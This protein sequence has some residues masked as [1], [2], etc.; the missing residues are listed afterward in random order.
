MSFSKLVE[1]GANLA[2]IVVACLLA[3]VLVKNHL[4]NRPS[5]QV[6]K[7]LAELGERPNNNGLV[8]GTNLSALNVNWKDSNQTLVLALST[9]CHFCTESAP[10]YKTI[11]QSKGG[12][13]IVA[14]LPQPVQLGKSYLKNLGVSVDEVREVGLDKIMVRGTPTLLMVDSNGRVKD[15]WVGKLRSDQEEAVLAAMKVK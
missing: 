4:L 1:L 9:T 11:N 5:A 15:F 2:I 10:F 13:R 3:A 14:V 7:P 12:T 6:E 8:N